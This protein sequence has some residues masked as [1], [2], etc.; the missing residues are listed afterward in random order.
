MTIGTLFFR[1]SGIILLSDGDREETPLHEERPLALLA[2]LDTEVAFEP[3]LTP[4]E[5]MRSL[6][7][8]SDLVSEMAWCDFEAWEREIR[9]P[10]LR[11]VGEDDADPD[12]EKPFSLLLCPVIQT[13]GRGG[14]ENLTLEVDWNLF[15]EVDRGADP[16]TGDRIV[17]RVGLSFV[18]ARDWSRL[19]I[20][21]E[22]SP[23]IHQIGHLKPFSKRWV[24]EDDRLATMRTAPTL[25]RTVILGF[26]DSISL[27]GDPDQTRRTLEA[28]KSRTRNG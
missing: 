13:I 4:A 19:P 5:I 28:I 23:E 17:S 25:Y 11:V 14:G 27:Y 20:R 1:R 22:T 16:A 7:P 12:M 15:G 9:K 2:Q 26:L 3:G 6:M 10:P 8:W 24:D 21:I 18:D